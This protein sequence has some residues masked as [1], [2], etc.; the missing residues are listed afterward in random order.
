MRTDC[1]PCVRKV[2]ALVRASGSI[3]SGTRTSIASANGTRSR[4]DT[5]LPERVAMKLTG[6]KTRSVFE[7]YNI[8]S[9]GDLRTA[10]ERLRGLLGTVQGQSETASPMTGA[11]PSDLFE[12]WRRRP[13]LNR[14]WRF[15]RPLPYHLATA[16]SER[17]EEG[18]GIPSGSR[19]RSTAFDETGA[20]SHCSFTYCVHTASTTVASR[21]ARTRCYIAC[22]TECASGPT[23]TKR[24]ERSG[25]RVP[26]SEARWHW[27]GGN[28]MPGKNGAG[29]GIR[30][31]DFD[32]GKVALYH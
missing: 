14:G 32:L 22:A 1:P 30:T 4:S 8:V 7:R 6:H 25:H 24:A 27:G 29:N 2:V 21:A 28:P 9:D 19:I 23:T 3:T 13:D 10:A 5:A 15:C 18:T 11:K 20:F 12:I 26:R 31:R 16:P 17:L